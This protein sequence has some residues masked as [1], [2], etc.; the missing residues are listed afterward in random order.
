[1]VPHEHGLQALPASVDSVVDCWAMVCSAVA[2]ATVAFGVPPDGGNGDPGGCVPGSV[3]LPGGCFHN[4]GHSSDGAIESR[5]ER[6]FGARASRRFCGNPL[7]A[8]ERPRPTGG[9][10][11]D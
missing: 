11:D 10:G 8:R 6:I 4:P 7:A 2:C 3:C 1:A 9:T 5:W